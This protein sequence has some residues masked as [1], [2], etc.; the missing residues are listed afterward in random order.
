M[1]KNLSGYGWVLV[2]EVLT[3]NRHHLPQGQ[4]W[5]PEGALNPKVSDSGSQRPTQILVD[6]RSGRSHSCCVRSLD[7]WISDTPFG[8][9]RTHHSDAPKIDASKELEQMTGLRNSIIAYFEITPQSNGEETV[10]CEEQ[11][12]KQALR[13]F[14][15]VRILGAS[16]GKI[17][18]SGGR[19]CCWSG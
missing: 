2:P 4:R 5:H 6:L 7:P 8:T 13:Q 3:K 19:D 10:L 11:R 14:K 18:N 12:G 17:F 16:W 1:L 15:C 9:T